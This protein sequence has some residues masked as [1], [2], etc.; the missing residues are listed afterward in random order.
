MS[1]VNTSTDTA[2]TETSGTAT[3]LSAE[4]TAEDTVETG[5]HAAADRARTASRR[6]ARATRAWKD[7]GLL[8]IGSNIV[9]KRDLVLAANAKDV[10]A[11]RDKGTSPALLD[12]LT[13]TPERIDALAAALSMLA[14]LPDPVGSVA[15]GQTL[16]NGL[17][18]RQVHVP[19]GVVAAIYE[20]R[21]NVTVD[22]AGLALKSGNAVL[23]RGGSAAENTNAVL[24]DIIRDSLDAVGLPADAVQSVDSYGRAGANVL[25]KARG[26]VD[27]LIP[28]GGRDLIQTVVANAAVPV[29][30]TGEGNV[31][32]YLDSSAPAE[33]AVDILLNAKTQRPSVCNT[34]ETLLVHRDAAAT[35]DV[36]A[37]LAAAGVRLHADERVRAVLPAGV[38]AQAAG[39]EDWG[40]EYMDLDLAVAMVDDLDAALAHIRKWTTGHTEAIIT[41]DLANAERFIAEIDSAAVIVNASTRFTDGGELGLGAEVGISTQKMHARGPMGLREL[42]TTKW[43]V[44]GDGQIRV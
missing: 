7:R 37:A 30:E 1:A 32:I 39:D 27:V 40:R 22:I 14:G 25:M 4:A 11:G 23:L 9:A 16:P 41:N 17:R 12:R 5:V 29:I 21:P 43:I 19:M 44:Q 38:E 20:A 35:G 15:R 3:E 34:V 31:H 2:G 10:A 18:L 36:L 6:L 24:V 28:R 8:E 13:L 33:M 42:T 26:K